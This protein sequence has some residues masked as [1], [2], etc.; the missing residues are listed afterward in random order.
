MNALEELQKDKN[1]A[2]FEVE[3]VIKVLH[4]A[5]ARELRN[6]QPC[7]EK[8][9]YQQVLEEVDAINQNTQK[10]QKDM[11]KMA[12]Q[13]AGLWNVTLYKDTNPQFFNEEPIP[14]RKNGAS[15]QKGASSSSVPRKKPSSSSDSTKTKKQSAAS[16]SQHSRQLVQSSSRTEDNWEANFMQDVNL[17]LKEQSKEIQRGIASQVDADVALKVQRNELQPLTGQGPPVSKAELLQ[18]VASALEALPDQL[19]RRV[20]SDESASSRNAEK[21]PKATLARPDPQAV[22]QQQATQGQ[23]APNAKRAR[24]ESPQ[25]VNQQQATQG[26]RA[27]LVF[28]QAVNQQQATQGQ[29][30]RLVFPQAVNQQQ[31]T[32]GQQAPNA[33]RARPDPQAVNQQQAPKPPEVIILD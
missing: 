6:Q 20:S 21:S 17:A 11:L 9:F 29:R 33:K 27:R 28:P 4:C 25:A 8:M 32:Q 2:P 1:Y 22:N 23:Q 18:I 19:A 26:Q 24:L 10:T 14:D 15:S 13:A 12:F 16:G 31:A 30:A 3:A 5:L 7:T